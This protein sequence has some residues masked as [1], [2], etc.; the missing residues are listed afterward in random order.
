MESRMVYAL[1][2][3]S[4]YM[5]WCE[6]L[7][8]S[9]F[10]PL[11]KTEFAII[12]ACTPMEQA[13]K[14]FLE[15]R[16]AGESTLA[17]RLYSSGVIAPSVKAL[18]LLK[19][20][21]RVAMQDL[22]VVQVLS[23]NYSGRLLRTSGKIEGLGFC[24]LSF[25]IALINPWGSD[26]VCLDVHVCRE[27]NV[28]PAWCYSKVEHYQKIEDILISEAD[29]L[30]LPPLVYQWAVWDRQRVLQNRIPNDH[31]FLWRGGRR[32]YQQSLF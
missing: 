28:K 3:A 29:E 5:K 26:V 24:K 14:G 9:P 23:G 11:D 20:R 1:T 2:R 31:S 12:S 30:G 8:N 17:H 21:D 7:A 32:N 16:G 19:L 15:S 22:F 27:Y 10:S 25:A 4:R 13:I 6:E 18:R